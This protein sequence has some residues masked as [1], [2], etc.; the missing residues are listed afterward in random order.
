MYQINANNK[1]VSTGTEIVSHI[2]LWINVQGKLNY[3]LINIILT[4][5]L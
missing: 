5:I 3:A 1:A 4:Y 2:N